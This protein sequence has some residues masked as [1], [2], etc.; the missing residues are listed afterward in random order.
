M[1]SAEGDYLLTA[2]SHGFKAE[3]TVHVIA[4]LTENIALKKTVTASSGEGSA[5]SANDGND[6]TRWIASSAGENVEWLEIDLGAFYHLLRSSI[7][8]ERASAADYDIEVSSDRVRRLPVDG[9]WKMQAERES[10]KSVSTDWVV[11]SGCVAC[12]RLHNGLIQ[13]LNGSF[14]AVGWKPANLAAWSWT[15]RLH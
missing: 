10:T 9:V 2:S 7:V 11:T 6:G 14:M 4:T 8:W 1:A 15:Y 5:S 3:A 12:V 13:F